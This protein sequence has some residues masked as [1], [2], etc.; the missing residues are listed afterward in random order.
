M[1]GIV[2][3]GGRAYLPPVSPLLKEALVFTHNDNCEGTQKTLDCFRHDFH[4]PDARQ[5]VQEY[6]RTCMTCQRN[7]MENLHPVGRL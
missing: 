3:Y 2:T 4:T 7:K 5:V 1:D 6:V